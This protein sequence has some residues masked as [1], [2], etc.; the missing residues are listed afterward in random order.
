M[1]HRPGWHIASSRLL[2]ML[3]A[4]TDLAACLLRNARRQGHIA[5]HSP[6]RA[7]KCR[8]DTERM[9]QHPT[10]DLFEPVPVSKNN[11]GSEYQSPRLWLPAVG[12]GFFNANLRQSGASM[13]NH[14]HQP[15]RFEFIHAFAAA[16]QRLR[17]YIGGRRKRGC[18]RACLERM[19]TLRD[20]CCMSHAP[21]AFL[22][23]DGH[24]FREHT[25]QKKTGCRFLPSPRPIHPFRRASTYCRRFNHRIGH[26]RS[27]DRKKNFRRKMGPT[28]AGK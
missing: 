26:H 11:P 23:I 3:E 10:R 7:H 5:R 13:I 24:G 17:P 1:P 28:H 27:P 8:P 18:E 6:G 14:R 4:Q 21:P 15:N 22:Q 19:C 16:V 20:R 9:G 25:R 12:G 2:P